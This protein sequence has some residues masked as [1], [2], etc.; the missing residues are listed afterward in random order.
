MPGL[1]P[2]RYERMA[3]SPFTYF[4]GAASTMAFDLG[5]APSTGVYVQLGGDSHLKN[6]G[7]FG[8]PTG[9]FS[10]TSTTSTRRCPVRG[11]ST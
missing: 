7:V 3:E 9:D 5:N 2:I 8:S 4:R 10:S 1:L 6:F 11:S